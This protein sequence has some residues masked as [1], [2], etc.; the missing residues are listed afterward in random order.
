MTSLYSCWAA[1]SEE[2]QEKAEKNGKWECARSHFERFPKGRIED[3]KFH[4]AF[5]MDHIRYSLT[6]FKFRTAWIATRMSRIALINMPAYP[7][8]ATILKSSSASRPLKLSSPME[9]PPNA[10]PTKA[11]NPFE[12]HLV[13]NEALA[14]S[15]KSR[16]SPKPRPSPAS[17][18][19]CR[20]ASAAC[21]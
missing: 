11:S 9:M 20:A 1:A 6:C 15:A 19:D 16:S 3:I 13:T 2:D 12:I 18:R 4:S 10:V 5:P 14:L 17:T 21:G 7:K 8:M